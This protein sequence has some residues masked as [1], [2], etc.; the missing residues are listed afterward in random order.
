M[1]FISSVNDK[2]PLESASYEDASVSVTVI[3]YE[4]DVITMAF[5][6]LPRV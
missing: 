5:V 2:S 6:A 3:V 1:A 4:P